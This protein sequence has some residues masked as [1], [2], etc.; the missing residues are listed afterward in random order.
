MSEN[1]ATIRKYAESDKSA[2]IEVFKTNVPKYF[3]AAEINDFEELLTKLENPDESNELPYY[4]M[5]LNDQIIGCGGFGEKEGTDAITFVW[6][7]VH[8]DYHKKGYGEQL[9]VF[10]LAEINKQFPDKE[11]VL[12]TTQFSFTFFE[13]YGFRTVKITENSYGEGMHRYD[14]VLDDFKTLGFIRC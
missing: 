2:C 13:K 6:G 11:V 9:L 5:E 4:V 1:Q 10:R 3:M 8:N 14:M 7:M 12:D